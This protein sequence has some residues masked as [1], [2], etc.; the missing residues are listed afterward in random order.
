MNGL[1]GILEIFNPSIAHLREEQEYK[2][3]EVRIPGSEGD[4]NKTWVDLD[5]G[6]VHLA[7]PP[8]RYGSVVTG[9]PED[10][11]QDE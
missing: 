6:I 7:T 9:R 8:Q 4:P 5:R 11:P 1:D 3:L 10:L 2:R